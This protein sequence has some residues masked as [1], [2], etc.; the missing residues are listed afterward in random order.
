M[1][2]YPRLLLSSHADLFG[3]DM[4]SSLAQ[5]VPRKYPEQEK[6]FGFFSL[7]QQPFI[8]ISAH[9]TGIGAWGSV[10]VKALRY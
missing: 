4:G 5:T 2:F 7:K 3:L 9:T 6:N 1:A 8:L 10:V